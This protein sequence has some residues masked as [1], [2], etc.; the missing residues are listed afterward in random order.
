M[1]S[2]TLEAINAAVD[3][4]IAL[5]DDRREEEIRALKAKVLAQETLIKRGDKKVEELEKKVKA[6]EPSEPETVYRWA[7][8]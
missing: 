3:R 2:K 1:N 8:R 7:K 4:A 5:R 6:L